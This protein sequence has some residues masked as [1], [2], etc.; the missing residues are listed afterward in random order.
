MSD[1]RGR[2]FLYLQ[3]F[4][5]EEL[6]FVFETTRDLKLQMKRG[7]FD[8]I[9]KNK[10]LGML[11]DQPSTRTRISFEVGMQ[12]LGGIVVYLRPGEIHLGKK[13]SLHDTAKVFD[14]YLDGIA[15]RWNDMRVIDELAE[16]ASI[17]VINGMSDINHPVQTLADFYTAY[18]KFG[19]LKG[20]K[21]AFFGGATN[22]SHSLMIACSKLGLHFCHCGPKKY[23]PP[24]E[25]IDQVNE[26]NRT[27]GGKLTLTE[28]I[29][30][31]TEGCHIAYTDVWWWIGQEEE[32]AEREEAFAPYRVTREVLSKCDPN[33]IFEHCLPAMRG[34]EVTDEVIDGPHSVV[35]DEAENRLHTEK[36]VLA[37]SL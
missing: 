19:H 18:E 14:R 33:V 11:F 30:K 5:E 17:P 28:D 23:F 22:V 36:A 20:L 13:E 7:V 34:N 3:D 4:T 29:D 10:A 6:M 26:N 32:K 12:Q 16:Y 9:L 1:L 25:Y 35:F 2:D 27:S 37:L 15:I 8:P 24:H 31:A 21:M